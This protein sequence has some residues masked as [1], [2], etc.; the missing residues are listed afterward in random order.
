MKVEKQKSEGEKLV[1][2]EYRQVEVNQVP[3]QS[4]QIPKTS[5]VGI[6]PDSRPESSFHSLGRAILSARL[7]L[8]ARDGARPP[9]P[10]EQ[11]SQFLDV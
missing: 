5:F 2:R 4:P 3:T 6:I 10:L 9:D 1:T 8:G 7:A 11:P